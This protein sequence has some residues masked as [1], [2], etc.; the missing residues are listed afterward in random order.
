[1][2]STEEVVPDL[3]NFRRYTRRKQAIAYQIRSLAELLR[4]HGGE[5][6]AEECRHLMVKLAEDRFALAVVGQFKRGKSSLMNAV[7]GRDLL[8]TGVLPLTS[9]ITVLKYG[10]REKLTILRDG[11]LYPEEAPVSSLSDF[12]TEK[13][14]PGNIKRVA[15]ASLE[16][17]SR[18]LRRG[19]EFI[20]TPGIGSAIAANTDTTMRFLPQSDAVVFVTSV[21]TPVTVAEIDFIRNIREYVRKI[22][23]VVNKIDLAR[24]EDRGQVLDFISRTLARETGVEE[25]SFFAVS[26]SMALESKLS[27]NEDN[28]AKSGLKALQEALSEFLSREK[29]K[30]LLVSVLDKTIRLLERLSRELNL[31]KEA[32]ATPRS[33]LR[34]KLKVLNESFQTLRDARGKAVDASRKRLADWAGRQISSD[35]GSFLDGEC[36]TLLK[37]AEEVMAPLRWKL[38][39]AA[40]REVGG[41]VLERLKIDLEGWSREAI[42]RFDPRVV[43]VLRE[44]WTKVERELLVIPD[45]AAEALGG[46]HPVASPDDESFGFPIDRVFTQP[47]VPGFTWSPRAPFPRTLLPVLFQR[48]TLRERVGIEIER[49][50]R[51]WMD[52][53]ELFL[54][55]AVGEAMDRLAE[56][57]EKRAVEI[58]SRIVE[59]MKGRKLSKS[60]DGNWRVSELEGGELHREIDSLESMKRKLAEIRSNMLEIGSAQAEEPVLFPPEGREEPEATV[61]EELKSKVVSISSPTGEVARAEELG[62][63]LSTRGCPACNRMV[64][65]ASRFFASWQYA[66]ATQEHAQREHASSLGF[67]PLHTWHLETMASPQGLSQGLPSLMERLSAELSRL[68]EAD[69]GD[70]G[71]SVLKLVQKSEGCGVCRLVRETERDYLK[72]L[73]PFLETAEGRK[74]YSSSQGLCLRHLGMLIPGTSSRE[75]VRFLLKHAARRFAEISEDMQSYTLKRDALR[76]NVQNLDEEDAYIRALVHTVGAKRVCFPWEQDAEI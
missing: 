48:R 50:T 69:D 20:D 4:K 71:R 43:E 70:A 12:V 5:R 23:F 30:T 56:D 14:N 28:Y 42:E 2:M 61:R 29:S 49:L 1:M 31:L 38:F 10:P 73:G 55:K 74:A 21:E 46:S 3:S 67:C 7:I 32:E 54:R 60:A 16:L 44:E 33:E 66:L 19:L 11:S 35:A 59:A 18:F 53:F 8:P 45:A 25:I 51:E 34:K 22:F 9:A 68:T 37:E 64:Q 13:G 52:S 6:E 47:T 63:E 40:A 26:S 27:R 62:R 36:R 76:R 75:A 39:G 72:A 58:E 15:R 41:T 57:V 65:M 17:P 24:E